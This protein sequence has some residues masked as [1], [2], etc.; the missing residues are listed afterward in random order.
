[1]KALVRLHVAQKNLYAKRIVVSICKNL[2]V[3]KK[4][5]AYIKQANARRTKFFYATC[6]L[7][8]K[9]SSSL[10]N[11]TATYG[12]EVGTFVNKHSF[13]SKHFPYNR[14]F[15]TENKNSEGFKA[16]FKRT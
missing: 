16:L 2:S 12:P 11:R 15:R 9:R 3:N 10:S 6:K 1:M 5:L 7:R 8:F 4:F 14:G 13:N